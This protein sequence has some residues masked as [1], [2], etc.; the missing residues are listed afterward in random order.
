[1]MSEDKTDAANGFC[2]YMLT[3]RNGQPKG[4]RIVGSWLYRTT[5]ASNLA[6]SCSLREA[7]I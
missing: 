1:M 3:A 7:N 5:L 6:G 4:Q 2:K